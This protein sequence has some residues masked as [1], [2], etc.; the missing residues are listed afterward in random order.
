MA[1]AEDEGLEFVR[2]WNT[3]AISV[4]TLLPFV[5]S[6]VFSGVWVGIFVKKGTDLQVAVQTSILSRQVCHEYSDLVGK[7]TDISSRCSFRCTDCLS[8]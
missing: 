2:S 7:C 5:L 4:I 6:L 1:N 3:V 8:R